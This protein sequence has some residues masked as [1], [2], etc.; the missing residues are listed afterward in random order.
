MKRLLSLLLMLVTLSSLAFSQE[1]TVKSFKVSQGDILAR[2][3]ATCRYDTNDKYCALIKVG[4]ALDGVEFE[5]SGGVRDVVK[6]TGEYWVYLPQNNSKLRILHKDYTPLEINFFD[7]GIGKVQSGVTYVLTL[8]KPMGAVASQNQTL[9]IRYTPSSATVLVDNKMVR[10]SNGVARIIL[11]V[12][13]HTYIVASDGYESEEG[14]VKLKASAPSDL[15]IRLSKEVTVAVSNANDVMQDNVSTSSTS[16]SQSATTSSGFSSTSSVSSGG[17]EISIPVKNGI[18]IDMVKV[19]AGTF[20]MGATSEMQDPF[21]D[22]K[23]VHQV[24]LTNDYYMGKYE[25][26]QALWQSVMGSNP[27]YFK[28]DDLPVEQVSWND[29]QEF[30]SKLNSMTD[31]KFRLPTEAEWEYAA[32]GGKKSRGYQ[33]S[34]SS[35][36]SDVAW[37]TDNSGSKTHPVGTK[38]ANELGLYD[39]TGNVLEWCQDWYGSYVGSSQTNPTGAV[40]GSYRV[41]RGGSWYYSARYCR[42]SFRYFITPGYRVSD[43]GLRL[44]LSE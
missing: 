33:Y 14:M 41:Y 34:G 29:C 19:E 13:Q 8:P 18:T 22:E 30:I 16:S 43:L 40:S 36:I 1:L 42:S 44:V 9:T 12:G 15:Q 24:T 3:A 11:P 37:Y 39:M 38:Q 17:N 25:V 28:G 6:K 32:R 21:D 35:N 5:C 2:T 20:M 27:S 10:G 4:I 31:R 23:P 26:T 7:Y